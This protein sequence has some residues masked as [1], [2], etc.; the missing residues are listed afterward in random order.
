MLSIDIMRNNRSVF[1]NF[2]SGSNVIRH[3]AKYHTGERLSKNAG[4]GR[5]H[6]INIGSHVDTCEIV[7]YPRYRYK[8]AFCNVS[9]LRPIG[10]S[11]EDCISMNYV[12]RFYDI[13]YDFIL[14]IYVLYFSLEI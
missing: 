5:G 2:T 7:T 11:C 4:R 10:L 12:H 1:V 13:F 8:I 3:T 6:G 14:N 9:Y